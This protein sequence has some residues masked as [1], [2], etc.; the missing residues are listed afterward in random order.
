MPLHFAFPFRGSHEAAKPRLLA[1]LGAF[2]I[3]M[4]QP[5]LDSVQL[6]PHSAVLPSYQEET[7]R[8]G[9]IQ[10]W[11]RLARTPALCGRPRAAGETDGEGE[12][13]VN[14][15]RI[16]PLGQDPICRCGHKWTGDNEV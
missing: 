11:R 6:R 15:R 1:N 4:H 14:S 10:L 8:L 16:L 5:D 13:C 12:R 2:A 3:R 9:C 7:E